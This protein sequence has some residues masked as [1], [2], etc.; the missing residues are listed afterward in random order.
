MHHKFSDV[1]I[2]LAPPPHLLTAAAVAAAA[3]GD[4]QADAAEADSLLGAFTARTKAAC[5][6]LAVRTPFQGEG[7]SRAGEGIVSGRTKSPAVCLIKYRVIF[8]VWSYISFTFI[9]FL[10]LGQLQ[11]PIW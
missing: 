4:S 7:C 6:I 5:T 10:L 11:L 1:M 2:L 8:Q 3:G 9:S